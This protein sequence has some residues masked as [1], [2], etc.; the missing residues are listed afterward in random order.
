MTTTTTNGISI[1]EDT[2]P[3]SNGP[4][5]IALIGQ[6][7]DDRHNTRCILYRSSNQTIS[8]NTTT[9]VAWNAEDTDA[10][11]WHA[12]GSAS[13]TVPRDGRYRITVQ[14][15]WDTSTVGRRRLA[16]LRNGTE[17]KIINN[18]GPSPTLQS[19]AVATGT[20]LLAAS[21]ILKVTCLQNSGGNLALLGVASDSNTWVE[22][23]WI[24]EL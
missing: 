6:E 18:A 3:L 4:E 11:G 24:G 8:N 13:I 5:A 16:V 10:G 14:L 1:P 22:V 21:D 20:L 9:D 2:D 7:V 15:N 19:Y 23:E 12:S 17:S